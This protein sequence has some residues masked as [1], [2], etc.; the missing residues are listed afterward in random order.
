MTLRE[1]AIRFY[2]SEEEFERAARL[3]RR[4]WPVWMLAV[5]VLL[6][7]ALRWAWLWYWR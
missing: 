2:G 7:M 3:V 5:G 4:F 1:L 6:G